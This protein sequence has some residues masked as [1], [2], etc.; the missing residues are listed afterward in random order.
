MY[1]ICLFNQLQ[2]GAKDYAITTNEKVPEWADEKVKTRVDEIQDEIDRLIEEGPIKTGDRK[3]DMRRSM[4]WS[5]QL[6]DL[7]D[8]L[9]VEQAKVEFNQQP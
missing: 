5:K 9:A 2:E 3:S 8:K 6:K 7:R 1:Q 4:Q